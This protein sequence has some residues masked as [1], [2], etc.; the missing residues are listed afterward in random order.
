MM[1]FILGGKGFVGSGFVRYCVANG[2]EHSVIDIDNY[3]NY[4]GKK[5]D[6]LINANGNSRKYLA[7]EMPMEEFS[8]SVTSVRSSLVHF[9]TGLYVYL[10]T[11]D[12]YPDSSG[13]ETTRE[14]MQFDPK[15][16]TAYGFHK[17]LAE[18]C[19]RH[20]AG[21]WLVVR[22][23]GFVGPGIKKNAVFDVLTGGPLWVDPA[24]EFQFMH[25]DD[26]AR[27]VLE[28]AQGKV[29]NEIINVGSK[30]V[31][32]VREMIEFAGE[33]VPVK[34]SAR[35]VRCEMS[36]EKLSGIMDVPATRDTVEKFIKDYKKG[37]K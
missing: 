32:S 5:C 11:C 18:Q 31:V 29:K 4:I 33:K 34:K 15:D 9:K 1:I 3:N 2:L 17:Y 24:S 25:T 10:S 20:A 37:I 27:I 26:S 16:Q 36:I 12:V 19:V 13:P 6:V 30:G 28:L 22:M 8:A 35:K 23:G 14:S 7:N 21:N